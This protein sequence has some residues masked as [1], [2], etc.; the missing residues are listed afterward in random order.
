MKIKKVFADLWIISKKTVSAWWAANPFRQSSIIAY[1]AIF[2]I[3]A[4]LV[5]IIT[6]AGFAFGKEAVQGEISNQIGAAMGHD[7]AKQIQDMIAYASRQK[8]SVWATIIGVITLFFGATGVFEQLQI[9]LDQIWEVKVN[10]KKQWLKSIKDQLFSF[11]LI[12]SIGFLLLVSLLLTTIL[13][14][15]SGWIKNHLPDFMLTVLFALNFVLSFVVFTVLFSLMFKILP[16]AKV[17]W[18]EVWI[19][20]VVTSVLFIAGK[21]G[22]SFYFGTANPASGYGAAG[23]IVLIMLW[24]SYSCMIVFFGA[25]FTKQYAVHY[26]RTIEPTEDAEHIVTT[27]EKEL[28]KRKTKAVENM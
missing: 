1:Y 27:E 18:K 26:G 5:I 16:D 4:L 3:P 15:L 6:C 24:V 9:S 22:L 11:G 19:G 21:F 23:S 12:I 2:S 14:T 28:V 17:K 20:A 8:S 10:A 25:E 13:T 7:T